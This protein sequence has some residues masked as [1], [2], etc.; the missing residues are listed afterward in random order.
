MCKIDIH[1]IAQRD[2][3]ARAGSRDAP[4]SCSPEAQPLAYLWFLFVSSRAT[5][6][7]SARSGM[8]SPSQAPSIDDLPSVLASLGAT[9]SSLPP[10]LSPSAKNL[11]SSLQLFSLT[12]RP[13]LP[14]L[15]LAQSQ[16]L[17]SNFSYLDQT[18]AAFESVLEQIP[19]SD[20]LDAD[21]DTLAG[22][23]ELGV[24]SRGMNVETW[25]APD[26]FGECLRVELCVYG[27]ALQTCAMS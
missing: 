26:C 21:A 22:M 14:S 13:F 4:R 9:L 17:F 20:R 6:S 25:W 7:T 8:S 27:A 23:V 10:A 16:A 18:S 11:T 2:S 19:A 1:V 24:Q 5:L 3:R 15:S 12:L